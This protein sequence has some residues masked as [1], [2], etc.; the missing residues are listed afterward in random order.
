MVANR[1]RLR[2]H[3]SDGHNHA[4]EASRLPV[5]KVCNSLKDIARRT[6]DR[7]TQIIQN[8]T[9]GSSQETRENLPPADAMRQRIKRLRRGNLPPELTYLEEFELPEE[10]RKTIGGDPFSKYISIKIVEF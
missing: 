8:A 4:F 7:P 10:Y 5:S 1:H 9:A 6:N 3:D 2:K